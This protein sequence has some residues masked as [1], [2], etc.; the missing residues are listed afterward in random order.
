[1]SDDSEVFDE[2]FMLISNLTDESIADY[3]FLAIKENGERIFGR[4]D[5]NGNLPK[6]ITGLNPE[7]VKI[8]FG[9]EALYHNDIANGELS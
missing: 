9:D 3:P 5:E 6:I 7:K 8:Y 1:L 2:T 4:S